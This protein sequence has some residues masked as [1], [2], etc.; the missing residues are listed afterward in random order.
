MPSGATLLRGLHQLRQRQDGVVSR[1]QLLELGAVDHDLARWRR[2]RLLRQVHHGVY[3]DHTGPLTF[4]QRA[5]AAV[6]A[7]APAALC[8]P[9][10]LR[11]AYGAGR[12]DVDDDGPIHVAVDHAR[13]VAAPEGVVVHRVRGLESRVRRA[14]SPPVV[15]VEEAV[16]DLAE[17][18]RDDHAAIAVLADAVQARLTRVPRLREAL[19]ARARVRRRAFLSA[20][21]ADVGAGVCS[22]LEHAYLHRVERAHGLPRSDRQR[23]TEVGRPG[24]R[25]VTYRSLRLHVELDGRLGHTRHEDRDHDLDRDVAAAVQDHVTLRLGWGQAVGRPCHTS[26]ALAEIMRA[27]GWEGRRHPCPDC[28]DDPA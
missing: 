1:Q 16:L 6:L 24:F 8:G 7:V 21:L 2:R 11:L 12:R 20:V 17:A 18:A 28:R 9:S 19:Q 4:R 15:R 14:A 25:D 3:V 23:P 5:W 13:R 27:R 22:T 10:A 26:R